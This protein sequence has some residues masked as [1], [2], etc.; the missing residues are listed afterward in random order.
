MFVVFLDSQE[1]HCPIGV[2]DFERKEGVNL[3]ISVQVTLNRH[4]GLDDLNHTVDYT[5]LVDIVNEQAAIPHESAFS[6]FWVRMRSASRVR[7]PGRC[8]RNLCL[9]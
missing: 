3:Y 1:V 4:V 2:H 5:S 6:L 8:S 9:L 7:S